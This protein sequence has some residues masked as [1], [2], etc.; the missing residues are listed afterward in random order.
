MTKNCRSE[1]SQLFL[2]VEDDE[3][4]HR[5]DFS[6][7]KK[8]SQVEDAINSFENLDVFTCLHRT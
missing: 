2:N 6:K 5:V 3:I 8:R 4:P 7:L 1:F